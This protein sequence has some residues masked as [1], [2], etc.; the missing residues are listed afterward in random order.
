[1]GP[2]PG[3]GQ[4]HQPWQKATLLFDVTA[5]PFFVILTPNLLLGR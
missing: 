5:H 3:E 1:M 2:K 4:A